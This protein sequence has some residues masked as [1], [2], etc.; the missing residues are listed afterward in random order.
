MLIVYFGSKG[1]TKS[2]KPTRHETYGTEAAIFG[3]HSRLAL[4]MSKVR[5]SVQNM[6]QGF[7]EAYASPV[8]RLEH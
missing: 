8:S 5:G 3:M 2:R 4:F 7:L 6:R 1:Q